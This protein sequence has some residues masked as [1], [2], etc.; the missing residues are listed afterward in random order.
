[1][2]VD[3]LNAYILAWYELWLN[4]QPVEDCYIGRGYAWDFE[5]NC[6]PE[7]GTEGGSE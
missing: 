1:M 2:S 3:N 6:A 4:G 7:D 5:G